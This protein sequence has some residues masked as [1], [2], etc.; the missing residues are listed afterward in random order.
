[1]PLELGIVL[2]A[3]T[4]AF[5]LGGIMA[6]A[7]QNDVPTF[8]IM[9]MPVWFATLVPVAPIVTPTGVWLGFSGTEAAAI[10]STALFAS[11]GALFVFGLIF[12]KYILR[13]LSWV[14]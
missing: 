4:L 2:L 6:A 10:G 12:W 8:G 7:F 14:V 9:M 1:M 13:R 3:A 5:V 11:L